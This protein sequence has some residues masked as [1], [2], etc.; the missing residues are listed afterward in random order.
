ML[1]KRAMSL[2]CFA[3][4]LLTSSCAQSNKAALSRADREAL[5]EEFTQPQRLQFRTHPITQGPL[6]LA[7]VITADSIIKIVN[8]T[9]GALLATVEAPAHS[10][11]SIAADK[12]VT[13]GRQTVLPG[14]LASANEYAIYVESEPEPV[15][16][17]A[18]SQGSM[19]S[20]PAPAP[21]PATSRA[22]PAR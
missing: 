1:Q 22:S 21:A 10:I 20:P 4:L 13:I 5:R 8:A 14:P 16:A 3:A 18:K 19:T 12:G 17:P 9:T 15:N 6:P 2:R 7:Q 11:V